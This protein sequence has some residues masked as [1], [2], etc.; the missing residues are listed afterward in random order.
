M[1]DAGY[2]FDTVYLY[3]EALH[4]SDRRIAA[5]SD[6]FDEDV[7]GTQAMQALDDLGRF[8]GG[9]LSCVGGTFFAAAETAGTGT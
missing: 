9:N 4:C 8:F 3:V 2:I 7:D 1:R 5:E 6:A